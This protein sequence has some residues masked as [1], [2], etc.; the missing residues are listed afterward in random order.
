MNE[1]IEI[2]KQV[3]IIVSRRRFII[4]AALCASIIPGIML[5]QTL[6]KTYK[7]ETLILIDPQKVPANFVKSIVS[8][9]VNSRIN[10]ISKQILSAS[11][12][13]KIIKQFE[14]F[15]SPE[16]KKMFHEDKLESI[17]NRIDI[18]LIKAS[19]GAGAFSISY[20]GRD[21]ENAAKIVN[22]LSS[23]FINENLKQREEQ[24]MGTSHFLKEELAAKEAKLQ[25]VEQ[26]VKE[27]RKQ[28]MGELPEQLESNMRMLDRLHLQLSEAYKNLVAAKNRQLQIRNSMGISGQLGNGD[29]SRMA[30]P[31]EAAQL[32]TLK[33]ALARFEENYTDKHPNVI[34]TKS[35]IMALEKRLASVSTPSE[36]IPAVR[37][38]PQNS[39]LADV[40]QEIRTLA[41]EIAQTNKKIKSYN[42]R[43]ENTAKRELEL[44]SL[45]RDYENIQSSY[46]SLLNRKLEAEISVNMEKKQKGEQFRILDKARV[47]EKPFSPDLKSVFMVTIFVG[48]AIGGLIVFLLEFLDTSFRR[49]EDVELDLGMPI[50][51]KIPQATI[52]QPSLIPVFN[53]AMTVSSIVITALLFTGFAMLSFQQGGRLLALL[54]TVVAFNQ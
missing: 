6:S 10:T 41:L 54:E 30:D 14:L 4:L 13:E 53:M 50:I 22:T 43:I 9:D 18:K 19:R 15:S 25:A 7:A 17:R 26:A 44:L 21:P 11:N 16:A 1:Y 48:I 29:D 24:A 36:T 51:G 38:P 39:E 33:R 40:N 45:Q 35:K 37:Q 28:Y 3:A 12:L 52:I 5:T 8:T 27:Y 34:I 32:D 47:P 42:E 49:P 23:L 20:V 2:I 46:N 31:A